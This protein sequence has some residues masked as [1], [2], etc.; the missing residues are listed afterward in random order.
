MRKHITLL[1]VLVLFCFVSL[2]RG[3]PAV[4]VYQKTSR[5][6]VLITAGSGNI[7]GLVGAGSVLSTDGL[8]VTNAHVVIDRDRQA[9]YP[10]VQVFLKPGE[11]TGNLAGDLAQ[12][13]GAEVVAFNTDLDLALLRVRDLPGDVG[14]IPLADPDDI[15]V[16]E[17][18][19][20]IGHPEQ[21][22]LWTLTYG[23]ISGQITDQG[24]VRGKHVFQTDTSV[25]RGN[26]G[27]PLL[28][29]RGYMVGVNTNIARRGEGGM[30]ITGVNFALKSSVVRAWLGKRGYRMAFGEE[31]LSGE[32]GTVKA[33]AEK[34]APVK[35][36]ESP[37]GRAGPAETGQRPAA[38]APEP[39]ERGVLEELSEME[40]GK[41]ESDTM[42]TPK[43]PYTFDS[44]MEEVEREMED[45]MEEMKMKIRK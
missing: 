10:R 18:V 16:G 22:G 8:I 28:D 30:A 35:E 6:V 32:P 17:E 1:S 27:G 15:M 24:S 7:T 4:E 39:G 2:A 41:L 9:P 5:A 38:A 20:A 13:H 12:R 25:N 37:S 19:V 36:A 29:R 23:R 21:G 31:P 33:T 34:P 11:V 45:L 44:L 40:K 43:K 42:L 14:Y 26:S 3:F